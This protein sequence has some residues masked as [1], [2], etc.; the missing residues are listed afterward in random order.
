MKS[1]KK[2]IIAALCAVMLVVGSVAGTMAYLTSTDEVV[3]TFT[4]GNVVITLDEADVDNSTED[5]DRDQANA[6]KLMP[7]HTYAKDPIVHVGEKSEKCYLFVKVVNEIAAIEVTE[8]ETT[9]DTTKTTVA[10][11]MDAKGW[12]AVEGQAGVYVYTQGA[13]DPAIV[14][15]NTNVPVFDNFTISGN[16]NNTTLAGYNNK[17]ITVTAYAIQA[18]GFSGKTASE[19]WTAGGWDNNGTTGGTTGE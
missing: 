3:N 18:D 1:A 11:Q 12:K 8:A 4:V 6:Y 10:S 15:G 13:T 5:K 17:A 16:V 19:I 14:N 9:A 2:A 7:G